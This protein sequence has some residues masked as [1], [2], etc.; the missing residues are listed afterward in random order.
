MFADEDALLSTYL[1][2]GA[3]TCAAAKVANAK[4]CD[5]KFVRFLC[6]VTCKTPHPQVYFDRATSLVVA[7]LA[8]VPL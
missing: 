7:K 4:L 2:G 3:T 8:S 6:P 5:T 1:G